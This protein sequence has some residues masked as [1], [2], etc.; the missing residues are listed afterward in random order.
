MDEETANPVDE[1]EAEDG[2]VDDELGDAAVCSSVGCG[3][4]TE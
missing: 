3:T 2:N 1:L 4:I